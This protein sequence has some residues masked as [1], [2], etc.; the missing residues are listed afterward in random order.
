MEKQQTAQGQHERR[1]KTIHL[2]PADDRRVEWRPRDITVIIARDSLDFPI[3]LGV[4]GG[5]WIGVMWR[6]GGDEVTGSKG[7]GREGTGEGGKEDAR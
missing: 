2:F 3:W 5:G 4:G 6:G 1:R 7:E